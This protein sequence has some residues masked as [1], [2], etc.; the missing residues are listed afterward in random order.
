MPY[1]GDVNATMLD[2]LGGLRSA[3]TYVGAGKLKVEFFFENLI[4]LI[5]VTLLVFYVKIIVIFLGS[6]KPLFLCNIISIM[7][8]TLY[9]YK[10]F[11]PYPKALHVREYRKAL[12]N[13]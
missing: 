8:P 3:C 1:R 7:H 9:N 13:T 12:S 5:K 2:V 10:T 4:C 6:N 11:V